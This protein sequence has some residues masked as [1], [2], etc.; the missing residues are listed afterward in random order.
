MR[1]RV[2]D[3]PVAARPAASAVPC[4]EGSPLR[5]RDRSSRPSNVDDDRVGLQDPAQ[6]SVAG[7][8]LHGLARDGHATLQL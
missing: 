8:P 3:R 2:V 7:Q 1:S 6:G 5:R 4:L